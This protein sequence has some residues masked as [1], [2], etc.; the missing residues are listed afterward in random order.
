MKSSYDILT[1]AIRKYKPVRVALMFSGGHDSLTNTHVCASI[2]QGLEMPFTVYHGDTTIGIPETQQFVKDVCRQF[3]WELVI[4]RPPNKKDHYEELVKKFGFPGSTKHAHQI[5]YRSL[6]ERALRFFVTH[7]C[8]STPQARENV[9]LCS[10]A[11][12]EES[13]IRMGYILETTKT[14]S[15]VWTNP[16]FY[17]T[18]KDCEDYMRAHKLPRNPVKD[19]ICISGECLCGAFAGKEEFAEIKAC[20]PETAA[21]IEALHELAKENGKPWSW[22]SGPTE[23]REEQKA[24]NRMFMCVGCQLKMD[25][26]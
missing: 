18:E 8:K 25:F 9:L 22:S 10:G 7:E 14:R 2:L 15:Q 3:G 11:R 23:W 20:Y 24:I 4:R 13:E 6:K 19:A 21:R 17:W 26:N 5:M 16:I 12:K 1:D